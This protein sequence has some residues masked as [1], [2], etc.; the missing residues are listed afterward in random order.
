M[1]SL[2]LLQGIFPAQGSNLGLQPCKQ[3]LYQ[4]SHKGSPRILEWVAYPFSSRCSQPRNLRSPALQADSLP[5]EL[6]EQ[7]PNKSES[8]NLFDLLGYYGL[9]YVLKSVG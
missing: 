8:H 5:T 1:D 7:D 4:L 3:I 2:F 9:S 6:S